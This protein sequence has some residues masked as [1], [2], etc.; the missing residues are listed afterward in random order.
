MKAKILFRSHIPHAVCGGNE[1]RSLLHVIDD[2]PHSLLVA[3]EP[4]CKIAF[5]FANLAR[6]YIGA[7]HGEG[8]ACASRT[9]CVACVTNKGK[10][11]WTL[12]PTA[13]YTSPNP[14]GMHLPPHL[15]DSL[16]VVLTAEFLLDLRSGLDHF[17]RTKTITE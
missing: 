17:V 16:I 3:L 2:R 4:C 5:V 12:S 8:C 13:P 7:G 9:R 6:Q 15:D 10:A 11:S 14:S 1:W